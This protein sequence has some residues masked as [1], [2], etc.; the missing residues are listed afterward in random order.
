MI[1]D[2]ATTE[3]MLKYFIQKHTKRII[4][5]KPRVIVCVPSG[6]TAVEMRAV[7]EAT[8]NAGA[9]EAHLIE[10]PMAAASLEQACQWRN[11]QE[12]WLW[13]SAEEPVK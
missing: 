11:L 8:K 7:Y 13:I 9:R 10:E 12:V 3:A 4:V 1:A 2:F 6:V 5:S